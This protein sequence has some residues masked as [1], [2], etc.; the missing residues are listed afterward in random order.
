MMKA[1]VAF[2]YTRWFY[3]NDIFKAPLLSSRAA[4]VNVLKILQARR[5]EKLMLELK[6]VT[7]SINILYSRTSIKLRS[8]V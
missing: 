1:P 7:V 5:V 8:A 4:Y 6:G 2:L 3:A